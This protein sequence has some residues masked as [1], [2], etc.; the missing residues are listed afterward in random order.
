[1]TGFGEAEH[2]FDF[3][4]LRV[5][6]RSVNHRYLNIQ[7]RVPSGLERLQPALERTVR[8][9]LSRGHVS[10][11]ISLDTRIDEDDSVPALDM[12]RA[13]GYRDVLLRLKTE[14]ELG[15]SVDVALI[16]G[17]RDV[18]QRPRPKG[19]PDELDDEV[20]ETV[21]GEALGALVSM[22]EDEG[23]R[24]AADLAKRLRLMEREVDAVGERAPDR[25]VEERDRIRSAIQ[26]LLQGEAPLDEDR[27]AR[28]VAHM[29]ERWD[30]H[31]EL[32]RF[33]SHLEMFRETMA[34]GSEDGVGKRFGFISQEM[35]REVNTIGSKANDARIAAHVVTLKEEVDRLREQLENVE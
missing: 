4:R 10:I 22:R 1:M 32:V 15:G 18:F 26:D 17:F 14:L 21:L 5:E 20:V 2:D 7:L 33:R 28:E 6:I 11:A 23:A 8:E 35:L 19:L 34:N 29:A 9:R 13:R 25:L 12:D 27:I 16:A 24:L 31:E 3:G 30:I